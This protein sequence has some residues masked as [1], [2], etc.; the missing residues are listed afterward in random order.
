M[1]NSS[2]PNLHRSI[3]GPWNFLKTDANFPVLWFSPQQHET[4][5]CVLFLVHSL[6]NSQMAIQVTIR[7][8]SE[9]SQFISSPCNGRLR[10]STEESTAEEWSV[11]MFSDGTYAFQSWIGGWLSTENN[12]VT[13]SAVVEAFS[14]AKWDERPEKSRFVRP[15]HAFLEMIGRCQAEVQCHLPHLV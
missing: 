8:Y 13:T 6:F 5:K 2:E 1:K 4:E 7:T 10:L 12:R 11:T 14:L 9:P 3:S 15:I